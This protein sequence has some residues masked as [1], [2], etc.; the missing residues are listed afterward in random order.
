[1]A[2][3]SHDGLSDPEVF[4]SQSPDVVQ[5]EGDLAGRQRLLLTAPDRVVVIGHPIQLLSHTGVV[6][7]LAQP[8][9]G[10]VV[11][12]HSSGNDLMEQLG[13]E[14]GKGA[15][16]PAAKALPV[17]TQ[18][19]VMGGNCGGGQG[20]FSKRVVLLAPE[21]GAIGLIEGVNIAPK[22]L[23]QKVLELSAAPGTPALVAALVAQ[24]VVDLPCHDCLFILVVPG[25][26]CDDPGAVLPVGQAAVTRG[27]AAAEGP[28]GSVREL[29]EDIRVL[30]DQP[31][32]WC[33]GGSTE[34]DLEPLLFGHVNDHVKV[35][36]VKLSL[37]W[38]HLVP[39]KFADPDHVAPQLQDAVHIR[40]HNGAVP[41]FRV[42]V[43]T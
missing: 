40:L 19:R 3:G 34:D 24:L 7:A 33:G 6:H 31:S 43:N 38:L 8:A 35:G 39:G 21:G 14:S 26:L 4:P 20:N 30:V 16:V 18:G 27:V 15:D 13:L 17:Q 9:A 32:G 42:I 36:E 41:L 25:Q 1:M 2:L 37:L 28:G 12:Y 10:E 22:F 23:P 29:G 11:H 5:A